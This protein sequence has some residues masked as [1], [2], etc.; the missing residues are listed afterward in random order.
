M[1]NYFE[2]VE[3]MNRDID[4]GF[5]CDEQKILNFVKE[6]YELGFKRGVF[7]TE[8]DIRKGEENG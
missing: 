2:K 3:K 1:D 5:K 7:Q 4:Y 6:I 8:F